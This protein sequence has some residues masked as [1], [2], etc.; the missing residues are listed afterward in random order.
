M[1]YLI[2]RD[3]GEEDDITYE[4]IDIHDDAYHIVKK[5]QWGW[6]GPA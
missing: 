4:N 2:T 6:M 5:Y 1:K 3:D